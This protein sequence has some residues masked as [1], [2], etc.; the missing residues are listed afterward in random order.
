[1]GPIMVQSSLHRGDDLL[2]WGSWP[3]LFH[4]LPRKDHLVFLGRIYNIYFKHFQEHLYTSHLSLSYSLSP[5][6]PLLSP[7]LRAL[8]EAALVAKDTVVCGFRNEN[9]AWCLAVWRG[10][11]GRELE[12]FYQSYEELGHLETSMRKRR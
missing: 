3:Q 11:G 7:S 8:V 10:W 6:S 12:L 5:F 1:M 4:Q 9:M 2:E